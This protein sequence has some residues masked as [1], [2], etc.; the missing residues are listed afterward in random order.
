MLEATGNYSLDL[1]LKLHAADGIALMVANPSATRQFARAQMRRS[2]SDRVD[3]S[4]LADFAARMQFVA[5]KPPSKAVLELR[6]IARRMQALTVERTRERA[7][8]H[9]AHITV[10]TPAVVVNDIE[11]NIRHLERRP[12]SGEIRFAVTTHDGMHVDS[13]LID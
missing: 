3:A 10:T 6:G 8:L 7:R 13:I 4:V 5:W 2:K 1:A 11:V 9:Q 12:G